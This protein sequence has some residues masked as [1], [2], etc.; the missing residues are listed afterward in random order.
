MICKYIASPLHG[1]SVLHLLQRLVPGGVWSALHHPPYD[2]LMTKGHEAEP[3]HPYRT[4]SCGHFWS[5][6]DL[7]V[8]RE[9]ALLAPERHTHLGWHDH[10]FVVA[11]PVLW[12]AAWSA[13][14]DMRCS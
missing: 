3:P 11:S 13:L 14:E 1:A 7:C 9:E 6:F 4:I 2:T 8:W 10:S 12:R 5:D